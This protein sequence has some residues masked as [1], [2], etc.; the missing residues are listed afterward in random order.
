MANALLFQEY[1]FLTRNA[2]TENV[3]MVRVEFALLLQIAIQKN[4]GASKENA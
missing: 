3:P 2:D 1:A 4:F